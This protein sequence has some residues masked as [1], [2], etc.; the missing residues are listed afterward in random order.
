[1]A[2]DHAG[3]SLRGFRDLLFRLQITGK[4]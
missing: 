2:A 1:M 4:V 3:Y